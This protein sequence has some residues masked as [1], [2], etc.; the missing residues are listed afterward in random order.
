MVALARRPDELAHLRLLLYPAD[1]RIHLLR[2]AGEV[3]VVVE[4]ESLHQLLT[5]LDATYGV[6]AFVQARCPQTQPHHIGNDHHHPP[7]DAALGGQPDGERELA[8]EVVH[9]A[10]DHQREAMLD[11][12]RAQDPLARHRRDAAVRQRRGE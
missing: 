2:D 8:R 5:E 7:A 11:G 4:V 1:P 12:L 9:P 3:V 10:R 6:T